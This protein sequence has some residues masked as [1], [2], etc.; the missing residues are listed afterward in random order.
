MPLIQ[1]VISWPPGFRAWIKIPAKNPPQ[2]AW[3]VALKKASFPLNP[4]KAGDGLFCHH[5]STSWNDTWLFDKLRNR[6]QKIFWVIS[7]SSKNSR[8]VDSGDE[9]IFSSA[10]Y[11][12][13][14]RFSRFCVKIKEYPAVPINRGRES[15]SV[16]EFYLI[17]DSLANPEAPMI[18]I[19]QRRIN[20]LFAP[21]SFPG[22]ALA[23]SVHVNGE[24]VKGRISHGF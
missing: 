19:L 1:N 13:C 24:L 11:L 22:N 5:V 10:I 6:N 23:F 7:H 18:G 8:F 9:W 17:Y 16:K 14:C 12:I 15:P 3:N 4:E 21:T 20:L 2:P